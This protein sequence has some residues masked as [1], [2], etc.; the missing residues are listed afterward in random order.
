MSHKYTKKDFLTIPNALSLFRLCLVPL[1][2]WVYCVP[3][4]YIAAVCIIALSALTDIV[5]GKIARK[6]NMVS[7]VGKALDPLADKITQGALI[8]CLATRYSKIWYL[9]RSCS[10]SFLHT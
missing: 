9:V 4:E 10:S 2:I 1:L 6:F 3:K 8:F 7:D 5:D